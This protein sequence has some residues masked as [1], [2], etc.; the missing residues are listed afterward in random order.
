ML[1]SL[2]PVLPLFSSFYAPQSI[3]SPLSPPPKQHKDYREKKLRKPF[4]TVQEG[5]P[6]SGTEHVSSHNAENNCLDKQIISKDVGE[7]ENDLDERE[8]FRV[9]DVNEGRKKVCG[10]NP[11]HVV[12]DS[13]E[14]LQKK[15]PRYEI[16]SDALRR[17]STGKISAKQSSK[18]VDLLKKL[19]KQ[20]KIFKN[21]L[22]KTNAV[23]RECQLEASGNPDFV[24]V[25]LNEK[26]KV[27]PL[28]L[29]IIRNPTGSID[30]QIIKP[31]FIIRFKKTLLLK[32]KA[33]L[34]HCVEKQKSGDILEEDQNYDSMATCDRGRSSKYSLRKQEL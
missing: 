8:D 12:R 2:Y 16:T 32:C 22:E 33:F 26:R 4:D 1:V 3:S 23:L 20:R 28:R 30:Y 27:S 5:F 9:H 14:N 29:R 15:R 21:V 25:K 31:Q 6:K 10:D 34:N 18:I 13:L 11:L 24:E 7:T 17:H 19:E